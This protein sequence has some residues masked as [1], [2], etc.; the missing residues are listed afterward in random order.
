MF[1]C[2][3]L[4]AVVNGIGSTALIVGNKP[5]ILMQDDDHVNLCYELRGTGYGMRV[6]R[7]GFNRVSGVRC[8]V[9]GV[10]DRRL[11]AET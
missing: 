9:S 6:A 11:D 8:Q 5:E 4:F 10:S 2:F 1:S 7:Y 3:L